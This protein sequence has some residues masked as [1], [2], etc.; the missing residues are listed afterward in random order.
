MVVSIFYFMQSKSKT[1]ENTNLDFAKVFSST[2]EKSKTSHED[3]CIW[4][5]S[6]G[7]YRMARVAPTSTM[8]WNMTIKSNQKPNII[9]T[10][11]S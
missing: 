5:E 11:Y 3:V 10:S 2:P 7:L 8:T 4:H 1:E 9:T 6:D